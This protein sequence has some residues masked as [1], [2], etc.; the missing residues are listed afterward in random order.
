MKRVQLNGVD[1]SIGLEVTVGI[2]IYDL[3]VTCHPSL[4]RDAAKDLDK[5]IMEILLCADLETFDEVAQTIR[6]ILFP[7]TI[8]PLVVR[9]L[10]KTKP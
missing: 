9:K 6:E 2:S 4:S 7:E 8:G 10:D 3:L 5:L 1:C